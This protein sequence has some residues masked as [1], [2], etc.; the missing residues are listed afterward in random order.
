VQFKLN[1]FTWIILSVIIFLNCLKSLF[2]PCPP[3][4]FSHPIETN[5]TFKQNKK[6][7]Q[8]RKLSGASINTFDCLDEDDSASDGN[9]SIIHFFLDFPLSLLLVVERSDSIEASGVGI[10]VV[11]GFVGGVRAR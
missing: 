1:L 5:K 8:L 10:D 6:K 9:V 11:G 7:C 2:T 4:D 3:L